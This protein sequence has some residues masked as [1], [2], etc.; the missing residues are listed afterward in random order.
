[1]AQFTPY[2][3]FIRQ[4]PQADM[5]MPQVTGYL[6]TGQSAQTMFLEAPAGLKVAPHSHAAQWGVVVEGEVEFTIGGET[7]VLK[8][9][10]SY[11]IPDQ[12]VHAAHMLTDCRLL[13]VFADPKRWKAK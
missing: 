1:M 13:E 4:W 2:A 11:D 6:L 9:G 8:A 12:V 7:R 10:D 3:D 5:P